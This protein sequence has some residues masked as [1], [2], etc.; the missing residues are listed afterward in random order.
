VTP[1]R[2]SQTSVHGA[3]EVLFDQHNEILQKLGDLMSR[4]AELEAIVAQNTAVTNQLR[5]EIGEMRASGDAAIARLREALG[6]LTAANEALTAE[7]AAAREGAVSPEAL[8]QLQAETDASVAAGAEA[9]AAADEAE[10][11]WNQIGQ[12]AEPPA[13]PTA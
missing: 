2:F 1:I 9:V 8:A 3:L 12:P 7:V 13:E 11:E 4:E 6:A 5:G 10:A